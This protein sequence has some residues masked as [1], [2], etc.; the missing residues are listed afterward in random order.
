MA[1][2]KVQKLKKDENGS[3]L[4]GSAAVVESVYCP[5]EGSHSKQKVRE[6]LGKIVSLSDDRKSGIFLSPTK[7]SG[8]FRRLK[9]EVLFS[10][11]TEKEKRQ[12]QQKNAEAAC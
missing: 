5:G 10:E 7:W 1:F 6:R 8:L 4:S 11:G 12:L 2:I 3:V 9:E